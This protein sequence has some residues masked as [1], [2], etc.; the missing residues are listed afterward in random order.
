MPALHQASS[1]SPPPLRAA[2]WLVLEAGGPGP[3][4]RIAHLFPSPHAGFRRLDRS[5]RALV[6]LAAGGLGLHRLGPA[7]VESWSLRRLLRE[8]LPEAPQSLAEILRKLADEDWPAIALADLRTLALDD[9]GG[10]KILRHAPFVT[11]A[12]VRTLTALP[13]TLR[14]TRIV[15]LLPERDVAQLV[16]AGAEAHVRGGGDAIRLA[17]RLERARSTEGLFIMLIEAIGLE[18]LVPPPIPGTNW[19]HPI[20]TIPAVKDAARRFENCLVGRIPMLLAG[21]GAYY[22][23]IGP[24]PA[25]VELVRNTHGLWR[26]GEIRGVGNAAVSPEVMARVIDHVVAH[27]AVTGRAPSNLAVRLAAAAGWAG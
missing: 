14:R 2:P 24:E 18:R 6:V 1:P 13:A 10:A 16:R 19:L 4:H 26:P 3:A 20:A 17:D 27:G 12:L 22:E 5:R 11:R 15:A 25:I 9:G 8:A 7:D 21:A 23:V